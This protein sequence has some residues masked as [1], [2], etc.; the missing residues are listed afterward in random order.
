MRFLSFAMHQ[1][2]SRIRE[3]I[4]SFAWP[5]AMHLSRPILSISHRKGDPVKL[6]I[7]EN[8]TPYLCGCSLRLCGEK[9]R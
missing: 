3:K 1:I 4:Y 8:S 5:A 2:F 7:S 6:C 9:F